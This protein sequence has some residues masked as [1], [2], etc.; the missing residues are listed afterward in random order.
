MPLTSL[1]DIVNADLHC[2]STASDGLLAPSAVAAR[3]KNN[4]VQ[5]WSLTDHDTLQGQSEAAAAASEL[6][7]DY[8]TGVEISVLF[9]GRTIHIVAL[10]FDV[11]DPQFNQLLDANRAL[12]DER[13]KS[14]AHKLEQ[15]G[16]TGV[17][18]GALR[19]AGSA[20]NLARP[21]FARYLV[22][23]GQ[24]ET[25]QAVFEQWLG[26]GKSCFVATDWIAMA[27]AIAAVR[28]AGGI[29]VLAHPLAYGLQAWELDVLLIS[30]QQAGGQAI[31]VVSGARLT[32]SEIEQVADLAVEYKLYASRGSD[33]HLPT[34]GEGDLG[35][36]PA[37][38]KQL[39]PV[40]LHWP[41]KNN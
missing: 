23:S 31:E 20:T 8:V 2:H 40:W 39:S 38:P 34:E 13:A 9:A 33:F 18:E 29:A 24:A 17:L 37:L 4:G 1:R 14:M 7:M 21:H 16:F 11:A 30:F 41:Q 15:Q 12:R 28:Q 25:V 36:I 10:G 6:G 35:L 27:D 5:L 19:M 26:D 3:A 22:E 32:A